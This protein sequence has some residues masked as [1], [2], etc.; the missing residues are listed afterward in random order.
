MK[1]LLLTLGLFVTTNVFSQVYFQNENFDSFLY[2]CDVYNEFG[3]KTIDYTSDQ[4]H[5]RIYQDPFNK[6]E[7][8]RIFFYDLSGNQT[9]VYLLRYN[10]NGEL[11][12][13][14]EGIGF[15]GIFGN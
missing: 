9:D 14:H 15:V 6:K 13:T 11:V 7:A 2:S 8:K 3:V 5:L 10:N 1:N 4:S 12:T